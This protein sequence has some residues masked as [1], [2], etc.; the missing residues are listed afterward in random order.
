M[1]KSSKRLSKEISSLLTRYILLLVIG[2]PNLYL[3][4]SILTPLTVYPAYFLFNLFFDVYRSGSVILIN[5]CFS[6]EIIDACVAGSAYY[7]LLILN[8]ALPNIKLKKRLKMISLSFGILLLLNILRIFFVGTIFTMG[9]SN[10]ADI[11]HRIFW[12]LLS[13]FFV[14]AIWIFEVKLFK[15]KEIPFYSDIKFL[16][17]NIK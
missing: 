4:Y 10:L 17:K 13:T 5:H 8:L 12:Y 11:T 6:I 2:L 16:Y 14:I 1:R 15:I 9:F 3:F 7:L